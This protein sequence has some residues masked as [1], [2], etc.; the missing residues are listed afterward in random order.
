MPK[1]IDKHQRGSPVVF[2]WC[3]DLSHRKTSVGW[4]VI[5]T[6]GT[7]FCIEDNMADWRFD[8]A[9]ILSICY[10][11]YT[12]WKWKSFLHYKLYSQIKL[13]VHFCG[14]WIENINSS[15][16]VLFFHNNGHANCKVVVFLFFLI[17]NLKDFMFMTIRV[18]PVQWLLYPFRSTPS[19]L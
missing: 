19:L 18:L 8:H 6:I 3:T 12:E 15:P 14:V 7:F 16:E 5:D 4:E 9:F 13:F 2:L 1:Q 11:S 17:T 10:L